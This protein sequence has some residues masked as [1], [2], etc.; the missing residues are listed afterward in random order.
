MIIK[1][2]TWKAQVSKTWDW[3]SLSIFPSCKSCKF[4]NNSNLYLNWKTLNHPFSHTEAP[5]RALANPP[6]TISY[7]QFNF[8]HSGPKYFWQCWTG[9][10]PRSRTNVFSPAICWL[11]P[12]WVRKT[13]FTVK[14]VSKRAPSRPFRPLQA[15]NW[16]EGLSVCLSVS[17]LLQWQFG[18][19]SRVR[20]EFPKQGVP[21]R[22]LLLRL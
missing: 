4:K 5:G 19:Y 9:R 14:L 17:F 12:F 1:A 6:P 20:L 15:R 2:G 3:E 16:P 18:R 21:S 22:Y 11:Y 7:Q 13:S 8:F 10:N